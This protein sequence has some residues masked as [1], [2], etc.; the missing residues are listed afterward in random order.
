MVKRIQSP[1]EL[2]LRHIIEPGTNGAFTQHTILLTVCAT[3]S[4]T[5]L[6]LFAQRIVVIFVKF[7]IKGRQK[8][9]IRGY[10]KSVLRLARFMVRGHRLIVSVNGN[11]SEKKKF[12]KF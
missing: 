9:L 3:P 6:T 8:N 12:R 10:L 1:I 11:F 7:K 5:F 2:N 4:N